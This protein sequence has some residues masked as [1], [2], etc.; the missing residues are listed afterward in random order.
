MYL[1]TVDSCEKPWALDFLFKVVTLFPLY[2]GTYICLGKEDLVRRG[3]RHRWSL[4]HSSPEI[5]TLGYTNDFWTIFTRDH[6][7]DPN[8]EITVVPVDKGKW[9]NVE[10]SLV[11]LKWE[12]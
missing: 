10:C 7:A 12:K 8:S 9:G 5:W 2:K 3:Q 11:C 4:F 6:I 1:C